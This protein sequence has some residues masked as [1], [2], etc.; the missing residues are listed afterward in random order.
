MLYSKHSFSFQWIPFP[1]CWMTKDI[2]IGEFWIEVRLYLVLF[3][4]KVTVNGSEYLYSLERLSKQTRPW[5]N[6]ILS[7]Q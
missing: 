7:L 5:I 4:F 6:F 3:L 1:H 2:A